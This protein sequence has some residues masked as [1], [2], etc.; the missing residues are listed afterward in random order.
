MG[1]PELLEALR[2]EGREKTAAIAAQGA[3]E[4]ERLRSEAAER[5]GGM[6]REH[7]LLRERLC[8]DRHRERIATAA[9]EAALIRLRAEHAL[10]VRLYGRARACLPGLR[11]DDTAGRLMRLMAAELPAAGWHTVWV[12]S[13]DALPAA[14][15]FP[16]AAV[17]PD[18]AVSG[19]VRAATG[20]NGLTV[21]NT[22]EIRLERL[23][24][25]LLPHLMAELRGRP[26]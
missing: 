25:D 2:R 10:S 26:V 22:F 18:D 14:A 15:C 11:T 21:D 1:R 3:A 8:S 16:G 7:E 9:R 20:D 5:L 24:P 19:G 23:W 17:I 4:E 6:Q 13:A 12:A